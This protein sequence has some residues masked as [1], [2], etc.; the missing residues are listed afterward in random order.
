M[1][2]DVG[3]SETPGLAPQVG[4]TMMFA[5]PDSHRGLPVGYDVGVNVGK[6]KD[7][8]LIALLDAAYVDGDQDPVP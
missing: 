8:E 7:S 4:W 1:P 3:P 5:S 2:F 6:L